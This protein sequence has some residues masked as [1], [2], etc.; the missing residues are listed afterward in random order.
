MIIVFGSLLLYACAWT[1]PSKPP[2]YLS[3]SLLLSK[4]L[5]D[6]VLL[7]VDNVVV[8]KPLQAAYIDVFAALLYGVEIA[9]VTVLVWRGGRKWVGLA[10]MVGL[11]EAVVAGIPSC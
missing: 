4:L 2:L 7:C 11:I 3:F 1:S 5:F 8:R 6:F 9:G 10:V